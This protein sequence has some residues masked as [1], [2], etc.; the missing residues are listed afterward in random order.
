MKSSYT[1]SLLALSCISAVEALPDVPF[2]PQIPF[3]PRYNWRIARIWDDH[4]LEVDFYD[5][6]SGWFD[7]ASYLDLDQCFGVDNS[8]KELIPQDNGKAM[9][10][11]K[12]EGRPCMLHDLKKTYSKELVCDCESVKGRI[13]L[14]DTIS[15]EIDRDNAVAEC[16]GHK[17]EDLADMKS[18]S[19][20]GL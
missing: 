13:G 12:E 15:L 7:K 14:H 9:S 5:R 2:N 4:K 17:G 19:E 6:D 8:T 1:L 16:F 11:C 3:S 10:K 20:S 18:K